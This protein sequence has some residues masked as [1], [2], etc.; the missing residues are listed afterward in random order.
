MFAGART[1][2]VAP[3]IA[4]APTAELN[5]TL[6]HVYGAAVA[7]SRDHT[8]AVEIAER[9]LLTAAS[10]GVGGDRSLDRRQL[11][12]RAIRLG[13]RIAPA[14]G[15]AAMETDD[16]EAI[17]LARLTGYSVGEIAVTLDT[18]VDDV[19]ARMRRGLRSAA[20]TLSEDRPK[21]ASASRETAR[22]R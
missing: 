15:F 13:V 17:A 22:D 21:P 9:V 3:M 6:R 4:G 7:A 19:K 2:T 18:S 20:R 12:E 1:R 11:V 10:E 8:T 16:R 5:N 14:K